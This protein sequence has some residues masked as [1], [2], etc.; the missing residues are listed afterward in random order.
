M[1]QVQIKIKIEIEM[2]FFSSLKVFYLISFSIC[3][4][5]SLSKTPK[6]SKETSNQNVTGKVL[7][8]WSIS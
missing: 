1:R 7:L 3:A 8:Q 2:F 6:K 4:P 5:I